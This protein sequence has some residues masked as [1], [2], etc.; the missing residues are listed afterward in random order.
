MRG[1]LTGR[2][3]A[4]AI[5]VILAAILIIFMIYYP[6][7][8]R[9]ASWADT[10]YTWERIGTYTTTKA[11][12]STYSYSV[13]TRD[14]GVAELYTEVN[15]I[16]A[17]GDQNYIKFTYTC[18]APPEKI[19]AGS[20]VSLA[21]SLRAN[22]IRHDSPNIWPMASCQ[23][24]LGDPGK[25]TSINS[26]GSD[27]S[28]SYSQGSQTGYGS[29]DHTASGTMP[30]STTA[31]EERSIYFFGTAGAY[32]WR[33]RLVKGSSGSG[34]SADGRA[35]AGTFIDKKGL[36]YKVLSNNKTVVFMGTWQEDRESAVIPATIK[37]NGYKYKVVAID[38][39]AFYK[40]K[41]LKT[42]TIGKYVKK[43]GKKA[44]YGCSKLKTITVKTTKLTK[45]YIG[46]KAFTKLNKKC[47]VKCPK[48]KKKLYR[49]V[50][51]AKGCPKKV[52]FK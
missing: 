35:A 41:K 1:Q 4:E 5:F 46:T 7:S 13:T 30:K 14:G 26:G 10:T 47:V 19:A 32:E 15:D 3:A 22:V 2:R 24:K 23:V 44:F 28:S 49:S 42:V 21:F 36:V 50:F 6:G 18:E 43:I 37:S 11:N 29:Q 33:Y 17:D 51:R 27:W 12:S 20:S 39:Y 25:G 52:K 40:L 31:G 45:K 48:G 38:E 9:S 16:H 8:A 34:S